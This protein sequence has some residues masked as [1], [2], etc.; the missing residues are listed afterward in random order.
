MPSHSRIVICAAGG[1]K[2]TRIVSQAIE[3]PNSR[4]VLV[5]YT[6]NNEYE[7]EHKLY[8]HGPVIP[9]NIEVTTWFGFLLHEMARPYGRALHPHRIEGLMWV[10]GRSVQFVPA[11]Q[12]GAHYFTKDQLIYSD[13]LAKFICECDRAT[14]GAVMRR[15]AMRFDHIFVD[16][17]QDMAGY[18]LDLL[19]RM[20]KAGIRL[21]LV[22][23]HRQ[24]TFKTNH[25]KQN[26]AFS[27]VKI[28]GKF[29]QWSKAGLAQLTYEQ[30][31]HRC[32]QHIADLGDSFYPAEPK[33]TSL[34]S[35]NTGH[36]GIFLVPSAHVDQYVEAYSPQVLRLDR[37]TQCNGLP[38][39]NF[40]ESKGMTFDR[41]LIF[42]HG[43]AK[44][45]LSSG[46]LTHIEKGLAKMYVGVTRA[47]YSIAFVFDGQSKISDAQA[48]VPG[49]VQ[50]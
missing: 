38:A 27:G 45:W 41:A 2:T 43:L 32:H 39:L 26:S 17:I 21:T 40:G 15:L 31:T 22:G 46:S 37:K 35:K 7:I 49:K 28:I 23:D 29:R 34:N 30:H 47:R 19:E 36:D 5:T 8:A 42:P 25:G 20:L 3:E 13:K 50:S 11:S 1:G 12:I 44:K 9:S 14:D 33:T 10:E 18:D 24:A 48:Y 16:E 6:R 4:A